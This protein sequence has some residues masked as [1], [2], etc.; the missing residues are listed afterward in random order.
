MTYT[1]EGVQMKP[2]MKRMTAARKV[3]DA[4]TRIEEQQSRLTFTD[5]ERETWKALH[6]AHTILTHAL[7]EVLRGI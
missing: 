5:A 6:A 4:I 3:A 1:R 2:T 7:L